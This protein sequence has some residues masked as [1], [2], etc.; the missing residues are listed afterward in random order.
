MISRDVIFYENIFPF[1]DSSK[2]NLSQNSFSN[3]QVL[4]E[5]DHPTISIDQHVP[6]EPQA[7][8]S[9]PVKAPNTLHTV[10]ENSNMIVE[11]PPTLPK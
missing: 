4:V 6:N 8:Y 3:S 10:E 5:D 7:E 9:L 2:E 1:Q 11:L